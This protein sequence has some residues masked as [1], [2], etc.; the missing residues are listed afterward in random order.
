[1]SFNKQT[2][3]VKTSHS[4]TQCAQSPLSVADAS[5]KPF[6]TRRELAERLQIGVSTLSERY[7]KNSVRYDPNF[8]V[9]VRLSAHGRNVVFITVDVNAWCNAVTNRSSNRC[10][11]GGVQ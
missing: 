3:Q 4:E 7:N 2:K 11:V 5:I 9:P 10:Q 1:M 6:L 8:P